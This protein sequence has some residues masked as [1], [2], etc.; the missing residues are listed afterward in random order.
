[1]SQSDANRI[2]EV[3]AKGGRR[4]K[5][6]PYVLGVSLFAVIFLSVIVFAIFAR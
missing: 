1:M 6:M 5:G 4:V 2:S 3:E